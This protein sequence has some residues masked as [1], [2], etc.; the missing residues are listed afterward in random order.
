VDVLHLMGKRAIPAPLGTDR[1]IGRA[2]GGFQPRPSAATTA[3]IK[4][5]KSLGPGEKL[6]ILTL[7][8]VTNIA[9][10]MAIDP[11]IVPQIRCFMLG[12]GY[13]VKKQ[14]WNKSESAMI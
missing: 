12:A 11:S 9:S 6:D 13:D 3:L 8:A 14:I 1:Q 5:V 7:G 2:W 4:T 10:A